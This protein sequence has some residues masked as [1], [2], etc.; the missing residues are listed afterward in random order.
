MS[1]GSGSIEEEAT[2]DIQQRVQRS[3]HDTVSVSLVGSTGA[4]SSDAGIVACNHNRVSQ[5]LKIE[6]RLLH[7]SDW[8]AKFGKELAH[9]GEIV[10]RRIIP[11]QKDRE[12]RILCAK[13]AGAVATHTAGANKELPEQQ[14][15][16]EV[17]T[18]RVNAE[19]STRPP[20]VT[21]PVTS[22]LGRQAGVQQFQIVLRLLWE[23]KRVERQHKSSG[24][25]MML[26]GRNVEREEGSAIGC[27]LN[28]GVSR[29]TDT[30]DCMM[31]VKK[32]EWPG[33]RESKSCRGAPQ[34]STQEN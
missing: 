10:T 3:P 16:T 32:I 25:C 18:A 30:P 22:S 27:T 11:P 28:L 34:G 26:D 1:L 19:A 13:G 7:T 14:C 33:P 20:Q 15:R 4:E 31:V 6:S 5:P 12:T 9:G 23:N 29:I 2:V 21:V 24:S 17:L 8:N